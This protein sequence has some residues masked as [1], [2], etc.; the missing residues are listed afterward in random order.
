MTNKNQ[1]TLLPPCQ[2]VYEYF[3]D[4]PAT[5]ASLMDSPDAEPVMDNIAHQLERTYAETFD[6]PQNAVESGSAAT[7]ARRACGQ[8]ALRDVCIVDWKLGLLSEARRATYRPGEL[9]APHDSQLVRSL[10]ENFS[11]ETTITTTPTASVIKTLDP[12]I[13]IDQRATAT[14]LDTVSIANQPPVTIIDASPIIQH[15]GLTPATV[16]ESEILYNKLLTL[17][18]SGDETGM[19][20]I[21]NINSQSI[22]KLS[23][24]NAEASNIYEVRIAGKARLYFAT[25]SPP[26]SKRHLIVTI[27]GSHGDNS[28]S[29]TTFLNRLIGNYGNPSY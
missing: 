6:I 1:E 10:R 5:A 28:T 14:T 19:P 29:Q 24:R 12:G 18:T 21:F 2:P 15:D 3:G 9:E 23:L 16:K 4:N 17:A 22:K 8:C 25:S 11:L 13:I 27:L 20:Q 7:R 26:E